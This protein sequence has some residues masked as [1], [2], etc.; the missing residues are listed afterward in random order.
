[1]NEKMLRGY[2]AQLTVTATGRINNISNSYFKLGLY[3]GEGS[4]RK[5]EREYTIHL[6]TIFWETDHKK[7]WFMNNEIIDYTLTD[8]NGMPFPCGTST[9]PEEM[10]C[11]P[12][13]IIKD[14]KILPFI[15]SIVAPVEVKDFWLNSVRQ[16]IIQKVCAFLQ[17]PEM[18]GDDIHCYRYFLS[19][20]AWLS[21]SR[22][23]CAG[24]P[25][26]VKVPTIH[27]LLQQSKKNGMMIP[28]NKYTEEDPAYT[29]HDLPIVDELIPPSP[30]TL[31]APQRPEVAA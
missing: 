26:P 18:Y 22:G 13:W 10:R 25:E 3:E 4:S 14:R 20:Q 19:E 31:E 17:T 7:I 27:E 15:E 24:E 8:R 23:Y 29:L 16:Y 21:W 9:D 30:E 28:F 11:L 1:M 6:R 5:L 2:K 12:D